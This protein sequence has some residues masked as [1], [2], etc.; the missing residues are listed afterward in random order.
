MNILFLLT[1]KSEVAHI[2]ENENLKQVLERMEQQ[3]F[4]AVPLLSRNGK[5]IGTI[6]EGDLL[7]YLKEHDFP[8][9][10]E[11]EE[12]QITTI[13]RHRDNKPVNAHETVEG[14]FAKVSNQNFVPVVD[15]DRTFIGIVTR[16]DVLLYMAKRLAP[17]D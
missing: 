14:L 2:D 15:D 6:T 5:Y 17:K 13:S 8:E 11:L 4:T 1:P 16:K 7:W 3:G 9:M 12:V 10:G